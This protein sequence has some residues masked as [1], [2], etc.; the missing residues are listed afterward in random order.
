MR[1]PSRVFIAMLALLVGLSGGCSGINKGITESV[2]ARR[3]SREWSIRYASRSLYT[4]TDKTLLEVEFEG[5]RNAGDT[6]VRYQRGLGDQAQC[7]ADKTAALLEAVH[8]RTGVVITTRSTLYL[9]RFD[10]PPQDFTV[11]LTSDPNEFLLPLF[12][13]AG[14]ESCDE[15]VA[16]SRSYPYLLVH[17]LVETSLIRR[18]GGT[19]LPDLAWGAPGLRMH[20]NN[21]TRWFRDGFANYAG[22]IAYEIVAGEIPSAKRLYQQETLVHTEPFS[23]LAQVG[24]KLFSW[25]QSSEMDLERVYYNAALGLFLLIADRFGEPAIRDIIHEIAQRRA[26]NGRDLI[27]ITNRVLQTDVR[28]LARDFEFPRIG[29]RVEQMSLALALNK[30]A[31]PHTGLF[32]LAVPGGGSLAARAGLQERDVILA[33]GDTPV[34]NHLDFELG[35]FKVRNQRTVPLTVQRASVGTLTLDLPLR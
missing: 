9:L 34:A 19:V 8:E 14:Q 15:I 11:S 10:Q 32:V 6:V 5:S 18:A 23:C 3:K 4:L 28:Q 13:P 12:L 7:L 16:Q 29:A 2:L 21:Y 35:L 25:P 1:E 30:G 33:V 22:F 27:E 26:T 31:E 24:D 17:E 20:V